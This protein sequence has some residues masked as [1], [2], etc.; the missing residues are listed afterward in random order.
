MPL[1]G[2][3]T[4]WI[5]GLS[6]ALFSLRK[7]GSVVLKEHRDNLLLASRDAEGK[8]PQ[9]VTFVFADLVVV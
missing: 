7:N 8:V 5:S 4:F 1:H 9:G 2:T 3:S 6:R